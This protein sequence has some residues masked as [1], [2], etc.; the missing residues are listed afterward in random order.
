MSVPWVFC[1][2]EVEV[3]P[4]PDDPL[5]LEAVG[6]LVQV[7]QRVEVAAE[8]ARAEVFRDDLDSLCLGEDRRLA[9]H[10]WIEHRRA[11][12]ALPHHQIEDM[13]VAVA[14]LDDV[15]A[16]EIVFADQIRA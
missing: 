15:L 5:G 4:V 9:R 11:T 13:A 2:L 7:E 12:N 3:E 1:R 8:L 10:R 16:G 6:K 14:N